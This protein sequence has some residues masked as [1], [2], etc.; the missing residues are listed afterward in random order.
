MHARDHHASGTTA[1]GDVANMSLGGGLSQG[2]D[3]A[4][5]TAASK[6]IS[7]AL[8]AGNSGT[9]YINTSPAYQGGVS[10][11]D[12]VYTVRAQRSWSMVCPKLYRQV[13]IFAS[14][15]AK[16][17]EPSPI[18]TQLAI[19]NPIAHCLFITMGCRWQRL[20]AVTDQRPS[21]TMALAYSML[22]LA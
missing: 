22:S 5:A 10:S 21:R 2:L 7:F 13:D 20:T 18:T 1:A 11:T 6:G 8:A 15:A 4:V 3:Q 9:N 19:C 16:R 17:L 12:N 14:C